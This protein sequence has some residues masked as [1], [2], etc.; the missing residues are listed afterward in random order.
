MPGTELGSGH[1]MVSEGDM[2]AV[3]ILPSSSQMEEPRARDG[4]GTQRGFLKSRA[5]FLDC[6]TRKLALCIRSYIYS[7]S[8][9]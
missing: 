3:P 6:C 7:T 5:K 8:I 4:N 1:A 9:Y 2:V